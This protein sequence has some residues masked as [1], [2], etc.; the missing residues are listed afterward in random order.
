[1]AIDFEGSD[2]PQ[3]ERR[4]RIIDQDVTLTIKMIPQ[5]HVTP[6]FSSRLSDPSVLKAPSVGTTQVVSVADYQDQFDRLPPGIRDQMGAKVLTC[7]ET[8]DQPSVPNWLYIASDKPLAM[9]SLNIFALN[10]TFPDAIQYKWKDQP[11]KEFPHGNRG[12][13]HYVVLRSKHETNGDDD[14][15]KCW[16]QSY[17]RAFQMFGLDIANE[18]WPGD[19]DPTFGERRDI[20]GILI[21]ACDLMHVWNVQKPYNWDRNNPQTLHTEKF[22]IPGS[23]ILN[24]AVID[25]IEVRVRQ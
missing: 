21:G 3:S 13:Y 12:Y 16:E 14:D 19:W 7:A 4:I 17:F 11:T 24:D 20:H 2:T 8:P 5:V 18:Y 15:P 1:M 10:L 23:D 6:G 9:L 25:N 22:G